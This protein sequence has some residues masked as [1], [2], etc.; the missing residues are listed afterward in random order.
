[1]ICFIAIGANIYSWTQSG[2][3]RS[4][5]YNNSVRYELLSIISLFIDQTLNLNIISTVAITFFL[6]VYAFGCVLKSWHN[7][8]V[9]TTFLAF[10]IV[11]ANQITEQSVS[12]KRLICICALRRYKRFL[13]TL[14]TVSANQLALSKR[15]F[16]FGQSFDR[17]APFVC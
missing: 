15:F 13:E 11:S 12:L 8:C 6:S 16:R 5:I 3:I 2:I 14:F 10:H 4:E 1:M 17:F 9:S 7:V